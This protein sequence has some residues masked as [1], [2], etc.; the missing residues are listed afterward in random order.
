MNKEVILEYMSNIKKEDIISYSKKQN[1]TLLNN[2]L[3]II[4][5]YIKNKGEYVLDNPLKLIEEIKDKI[6]NNLYKA[7]IDLYDKY[8]FIINKIR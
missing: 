8:K 3:D 6:S 7:L 1:I 2:E 5:D 4:Y